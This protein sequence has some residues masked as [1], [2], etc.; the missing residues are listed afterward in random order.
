M[1]KI[2]IK[3]IIV[4]V[5]AAVGAIGVF[6]PW[7]GTP[8]S[9]AD[10]WTFFG[11]VTTALF[12]EAA[13]LEL[14]G[15][16]FDYD[17]PLKLSITM[18]GIIAAGFAIAVIIYILNT[19]SSLASPKIGFWIVLLCGIGIAALPWIPFGNKK[20]ANNTIVSGQFPAQGITTPNSPIQNVPTPELPGQGVVAQNPQIQNAPNQNMG[21]Q[22]IQAQGFPGQNPPM[23][24]S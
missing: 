4:W 2:S 16:K 21:P 3:S 20:N 7:A 12:I 22:N 6:L 19:S 14:I 24:N 1:K 23:Q 5:V 9:S 11:G 18:S 10:G 17:L 8:L 13:I 15:L